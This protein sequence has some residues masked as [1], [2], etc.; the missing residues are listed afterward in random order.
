MVPN[1]TSRQ[2]VSLEFC[3][4]LRAHLK[5]DRIR[6]RA[7]RQQASSVVQ[8]GFI[9]YDPAKS[10]RVCHMTRDTDIRA[11]LQAGLLR[12]DCAKR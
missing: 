10:F 5:G 8:E 12:E 3:T 4:L 1:A 2:G 6:R 9:S 11:A 7:H